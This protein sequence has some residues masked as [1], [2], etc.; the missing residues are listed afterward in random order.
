MRRRQA[1]FGM[2]AFSAGM[3]VARELGA[4]R[5]A[6]IPVMGLLDAGG[7]FS[8]IEAMSDQRSLYETWKLRPGLRGSHCKVWA[9]IPRKTWPVP[10]RQRLETKWRRFWSLRAPLLFLS[11]RQLPNSRSNTDYRRCMGRPNTWT[12]AGSFP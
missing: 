6:K 7:R 10:F 9:L 1:L 12:R 11:A 4:Q 8:G 5:P 3:T 2:L